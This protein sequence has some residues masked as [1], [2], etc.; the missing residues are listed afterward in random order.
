MPF[1]GFLWIRF[2]EILEIKCFKI[3]GFC[4]DFI[5]IWIPQILENTAGWNRDDA[6]LITKQGSTSPEQSCYSCIDIIGFRLIWCEFKIKM[7]PT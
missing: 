2:F 1:A 7:I 4:E 6:G 5:K 3:I